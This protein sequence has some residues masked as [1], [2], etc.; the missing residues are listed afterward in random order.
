MDYVDKIPFLG[1]NS[2]DEERN[3]IP[4]EYRDALNCRIAVTDGASGGALENIKGTRDT[5]VE[6]TTNS[7]YTVI[8]SFERRD[9]TT[10]YFVHNSSSDDHRVIQYDPN[11]SS[12]GDS[13]ILLQHQ[14]GGPTD[15]LNFDSQRWIS[16]VDMVGDNLFWTDNNNGI[17]HINVAKAQRYAKS[18]EV[19]ICFGVA[20]NG[21]NTLFANTDTY[22]FEAFN[23]QGASLTSGA[24]L[25]LTANGTYEDDPLT[26]AVEF[27]TAFNANGSVN[28]LYTAEAR[29]KSVFLTETGATSRRDGLSP[30]V[31]LTT[32]SSAP[33]SWYYTNV[34]PL[35]IS[36]QM[37]SLIK[38]PPVQAPTVSYVKDSSKEGNFVNR[39]VFQFQ[40]RYVYDGNMKS[41]WSPISKVA[42]QVPNCYG[43]EDYN[44]IEV[45]FSDSVTASRNLMNEIVR[46][47]VGV[48][49]HNTGDLR[50]VKS[51]PRNEIGL[52]KSFIYF[53]NDQEYPVVDTV[54]AAKLYDSIP[55]KSRSLIG[56]LQNNNSDQRLMLGGNLEGYDNVPVN[57]EVN[58]SLVPIVDCV[59]RYTLNFT[60]KIENWI[61]SDIGA[62]H[63]DESNAHPT[64]G[65]IKPSGSYVNGTGSDYLQWLPEGG[66]VGYL[67]GTDH[68]AISTQ[69][70]DAAIS[71]YTDSTKNIYD[72]STSSLR[73]DI[74]SA[75]TT[76]TLRQNFSI[77]N[78][79]PGR[80]VIRIA[81]H[82]CSFGD[83]LGKGSEY[84]L[85]NGRRY[86]TTSSYVYA[87]DTTG[88]P[89]NGTEII[90]DLPHIGTGVT[91]TVNAGE[92]I[93]A[94][95]TDPSVGSASDALH[96][97]LFDANGSSDIEDLK[98]GFRMEKRIVNV[99][100]SGTT[101]GASKT[102]HNGFFFWASS[103]PLT[104]IRVGIEDQAGNETISSTASFHYEGGLKE[105][106]D[107]TLTTKSKSY[108]TS[109]TN[110]LKEAIVW[111]EN[112]GFRDT[113]AT[114]ITGRLLN[115][116]TSEPISGIN[117]VASGVGR[118]SIT[119]SKG[120]YR[121]LAYTDGA[122]TL[123]TGS[124]NF[125]NES[126]CCVTLTPNA[127]TLSLTGM[128]TTYTLENVY[129]DTDLTLAVSSSSMIDGFRFKRGGKVQLGFVYYDAAGRSGFV[130]TDDSMIVETPW[131]ENVSGDAFNNLT[132]L[133][134]HTPPVWA[135]H[136]QIVRTKDQVYQD[137]IQ[138][139][140]S[141]AKYVAGYDSATDTPDYV[142]F[143]DQMKEVHL[144][145]DS[146]T[147]YSEDNAD[148]R[149]SYQYVE[150]DRIRLIRKEDGTYYD[151]LYDYPIKSQR[152][153]NL[154]IDVSNDIPELVEGCW[155]E[156]YT[157]RASGETKIFYEFGFKDEI[158]DAGLSTRYHEASVINQ[159]P[160][161][162]PGT[163]LMF[164]GNCYLRKRQ[165]RTPEGRKWE[166][167]IE[168]PSRSDFFLS[169]DEN[170]G[171]PNTVNR[172]AAQID[173]KSHLRFSDA[174]AP[175]SN[176]NKLASFQALNGVSFPVDFG[177]LEKLVWARNVMLAIFNNEA[178]SI[179]VNESVISD[180]SGSQNLLAIG[181]K[182]LGYWRQLAGG[183]GTFHP[184]T[185]QEADG[186]V[187]WYDFRRSQVSRYG[188]DGVTVISDFKMRKHFRDRSFYMDKREN[189]ALAIAMFDKRYR[190]YVLT[191]FYDDVLTAD[192]I[193]FNEAAK[194]WVS[195]VS[196]VPEYYCRTDGD[197]ALSFIDG[198][199]YLMNEGAEYG[200]FYGTRYDQYVSV[201]G[202]VNPEIQKTYLSMA[203]H[204]NFTDASLGLWYAPTITVKDSETGA[205]QISELVESD[206]V[207]RNAEWR[208]AFLRDVNTVGV[209]N[210]LFSGDRL[211][212]KTIEIKLLNSNYNYVI[213]NNLLIFSNSDKLALPE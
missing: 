57:V 113:Y 30:T 10:I 188:G 77:P 79:K 110:A 164:E 18:I 146:L 162:T 147:Q 173:R 118:P 1:L 201:I 14:S 56:T 152:G 138:F 64:F 195:L 61:N 6:F 108:I 101:L 204:T 177:A 211:K 80:Y 116:S 65:G 160:G 86:Q 98:E 203:L 5:N 74:E 46:I 32:T 180:A 78:V 66:F 103:S 183:S 197:R 172:D 178:V 33:I 21:S 153:G 163:G 109:G 96:G 11:S 127:R 25:I 84:D 28:A 62:V 75:I 184:D 200:N 82:W 186:M 210:P 167:L 13:E 60:L 187:Y 185:V 179:Y 145:L 134:K 7:T 123:I 72:S 199:P 95:L 16:G 35:A 43:S 39:S 137:F 196:Y 15:I 139:V 129:R 143:G 8:G 149:L 202:N 34:Y 192:T 41:A 63:H 31:A 158:G 52:H 90:I 3:I 38:Y 166:A 81:S 198:R 49:E 71:A 107:G 24:V 131:W 70:T 155:I 45:N 126:V 88:T 208:A 76:G 194:R 59:G 105:L 176:E 130:N 122:S 191:L 136:Y 125:T 171:R 212:G 22:S 111:N 205:N 91:S 50:L 209:T 121:I 169:D 190:E 150:G 92:F 181:D 40:Y 119:D 44:A 100:D 213:I 102:D 47:E 67:A 12:A 128:G 124:S 112:V 69:D 27:A 157:P 68:Y 87:I 20:E 161:T 154:V 83:K 114:F 2:D 93:L 148:S 120:E 19:E 174:Y 4:G 151:E 104:W 89:V 85:N 73:N 193:V 133:I 48:K 115:S 142:S 156:I 132:Y 144:S 58:N 189:G 170:I 9:G 159:V 36:E 141:D 117:V 135:T 53:Y 175:D 106:A 29:G 165:M 94:D 206:F 55:I 99:Y 23:D 37:I 26:G 54:D 168:S 97:Y 42:L 140:L 51:I 207:H 182:V 17:R